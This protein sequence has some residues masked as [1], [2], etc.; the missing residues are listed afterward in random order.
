MSFYTSVVRYKNKML[1]RGYDSN[2]IRVKR[3]DIF[4][5]KFY[6]LNN[7][8]KPSQWHDLMHERPLSEIEFENWL[9]V[10]ANFSSSL[11]AIF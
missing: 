5:P 2:G 7:T 6:V 10:L 8:D 4:K 9:T 1:Y 11:P 3:E